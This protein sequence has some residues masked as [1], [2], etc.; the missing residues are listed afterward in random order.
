MGFA[1][2]TP[3]ASHL[4]AALCDKKGTLPEASQSF[5]VYVNVVRSHADYADRDIARHAGFSM[6]RSSSNWFIRRHTAIHGDFLAGNA[7]MSLPVLA[8]VPISGVL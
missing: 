5:S 2:V 4:H 8:S 1:G 7:S 6:P 3:G